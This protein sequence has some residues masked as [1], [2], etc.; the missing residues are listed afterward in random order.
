MIKEHKGWQEKFDETF[1]REDGL[2]DI[3]K[4]DDE[5]I[6]EF[7]SNLL[8]EQRKEVL[9]EVRKRLPK[10]V[11]DYWA[12]GFNIDKSNGWNELRSEVLSLLDELEIKN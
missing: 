11:T 3:G 6:K 1:T 5:A 9:E 7:I 10:E 4:Y 8:A 2:L 12:N